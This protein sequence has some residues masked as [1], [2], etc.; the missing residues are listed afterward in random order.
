MYM[1]VGL[2]KIF[3]VSIDFNKYIFI[4]VVLLNVVILI[5]IIFYLS[6]KYFNVCRKLFFIDNK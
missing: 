5:S 4:S 1:L 3:D 2:C 6:C